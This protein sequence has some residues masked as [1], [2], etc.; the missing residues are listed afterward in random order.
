MDGLPIL[1]YLH[2]KGIVHRD[3]TPN[4]II[5]RD[6]DKLP[7]LIDFGSVKQLS[8]VANTY[9]KQ[10]QQLTT[11]IIQIG[12]P[13]YAPQEQIQQGRVSANSDLYTFAAT[14]SV[15]LTGKEPQQLQNPQTLTWNF[16]KELNISSHLTHILG[17]ML[18]KNPSDRYNS[19]EEVIEALTRASFF[20][21]KGYFGFT[22]VLSICHLSNPYFSCPP[23][24]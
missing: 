10:P 22:I 16:P 3:L 7:V 15:L 5:Y 21:T 17:K 19:A 4:N 6:Q 18:A 24:H 2:E 1:A 8:L 11:K 20:V 13:G 9:F 12:Q 14:A 23:T